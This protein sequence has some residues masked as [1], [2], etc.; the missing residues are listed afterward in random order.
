MT[1]K[2]GRTRRWINLAYLGRAASQLLF[3]GIIIWVAHQMLTGVRGATIE[4]SVAA[5]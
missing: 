5:S 2:Q 3:L 4:M 1:G